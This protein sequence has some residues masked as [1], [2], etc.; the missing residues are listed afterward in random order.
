MKL[1]EVQSE[2]EAFSHYENSETGK[3]V[4]YDKKL[5]NDSYALLLQTLGVLYFVA[6]II[7][8]I[9]TILASNVEY[10]GD[11]GARHQE[12]DSFMLGTGIAIIVVGFIAMFIC[13][14]IA[15]VIEQ[16]IFI[17]KEHILSE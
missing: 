11:Y 3:R 5:L 17:I 4:S 7:G 9:I 12:T 13:L 1:V 8:G 10:V 2:N 6:S 15:R 16:N 14:G